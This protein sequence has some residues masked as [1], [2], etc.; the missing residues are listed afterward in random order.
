MKRL[1]SMRLAVGVLAAIA[2]FLA[3][4]PADAATTCANREAETHTADSALREVAVLCET[5][6]RRSAAGLQP[7][8]RN[9]Q[10]DAA[11]RAHARDMVDRGYFDHHSPEGDSPTDRAAAHGYV[12]SGCCG[13][14]IYTGPDHAQAAVEGWM[15]SAGHRANILSEG[16]QEMGVGIVGTM[17]VQV[18]SHALLAP[19]ITGLEPEHQGNAGRDPDVEVFVAS[20]EQWR[21]NSG[22]PKV[23][24]RTE[25]RAA[26][27]FTATDVRSGAVQMF[28]HGGKG[29]EPLPL[30]P[31]VWQLCWALAPADPYAGASA[32]VGGATRVEAT[33]KIGLVA[34]PGRR[35]EIR[36]GE[37]TGRRARIGVQQ[38]ARRCRVLR[39]RARHCWVRWRTVRRVGLT[40]TKRKRLGLSR[41][42]D[43]GGRARVVLAIDSFETQGVPY[44]A[45]RVTARLR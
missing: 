40:L 5:N 33:P 7:L 29:L 37:A 25:S 28:E 6:N 27:R 21:R 19:R 2:A 17:Y 3:S 22:A 16:Y 12:A 36:G 26:L 24:A 10:L 18:F 43:R 9:D 20:G 42:L 4:T 14:N 30:P 31:G 41:W 34:L 38:R 35:L 32:C 13:E 1:A 23:T 15:D 11:A 8:K 44:R 45:T 39:N